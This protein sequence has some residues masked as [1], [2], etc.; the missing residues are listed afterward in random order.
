MSRLGE[1]VMGKVK[2]SENKRVSGRVEWA[3]QGRVHWM[4]G[5][6]EQGMNHG[7]EV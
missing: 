1:R 7:R 3:L 6:W 2:L 4:V 5:L